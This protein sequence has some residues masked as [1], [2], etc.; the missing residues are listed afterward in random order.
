MGAS[1]PSPLI[2][3]TPADSH[4]LKGSLRIHLQNQISFAFSCLL[5]QGACI[6]GSTGTQDGCTNFTR[7]SSGQLLGVL[8]PTNR[9]SK[10][11][12]PIIA[13]CSGIYQFNHHHI[14]GNQMEFLHDDLSL[15]SVIFFH[16]CEFVCFLRRIYA[17]SLNTLQE[18][19]TVSYKSPAS[20]RRE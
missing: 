14:K 4:Q 13:S 10:Q 15:T 3:E 19:N 16:E 5:L 12:S 18:I 17:R 6:S 1:K 8:N 11:F 7:A 9:I 20:Y 2:P